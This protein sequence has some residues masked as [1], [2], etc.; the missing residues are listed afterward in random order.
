MGINER[1][2]RVTIAK[3]KRK[4]RGKRR[5]TCINVETIFP[6]SHP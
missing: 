4:G 1:G 3:E 5:S 6:A 2:C